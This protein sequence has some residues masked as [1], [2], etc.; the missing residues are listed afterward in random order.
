MKKLE[1]HGIKDLAFENLFSEQEWLERKRHIATLKN[2]AGASVAAAKALAAIRDKKLYRPHKTLKEFCQRECGFTEQRLYQIISFSKVRAALPEKTQPKLSHERQ[3]RELAKY[4]EDERAEILESATRVHSKD[5]KSASARAISDAAAE[6]AKEPLDDNNKPIPPRARP[7]W[8]R[9]GEAQV[10]LGIIRAAKRT[11]KALSP[12]DPMW[13][14]V[15]LNGVLADIASAINRFTSA[16]PA[17]VCPYC[18]GT[19]PDGCRC[20]KGRG[21]ISRFMWNHAVPEE[22]KR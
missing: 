15:N 5:G 22:M 7:Y 11:V 10:V 6:L 2:F 3:A 19:K 1:T 16:V 17:H 20:C 18:K 12:D 21:C 13:C 8:N 14:E 9:R 4:P